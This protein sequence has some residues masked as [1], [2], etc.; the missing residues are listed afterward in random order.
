[1]KS[2]SLRPPSVEGVTLGVCK[3]PEMDGFCTD[4]AFRPGEAS[5]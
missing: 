2:G 4:G 5:M 3:V 1:M